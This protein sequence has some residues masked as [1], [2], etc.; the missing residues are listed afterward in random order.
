MEEKVP[1]LGRRERAM[2]NTGGW[3]RLRVPVETP[4]VLKPPALGKKRKTLPSLCS[5]CSAPT[6]ALPPSCSAVTKVS[7]T[8]PVGVNRGLSR[9]SRDREGWG[10][11]RVCG[12]VGSP[13][14]GISSKVTNYFKLTPSRCVDP[15]QV[16]TV[17][18]LLSQLGWSTCW[19]ENRC[20]GKT[21]VAH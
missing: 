17:T 16:A 12:R 21:I 1:P 13:S 11:W 7:Q 6:V 14:H 4:C 18:S 2:V 19:A 8:P 10:A 3:L 9:P 20:S 15:M 5:P